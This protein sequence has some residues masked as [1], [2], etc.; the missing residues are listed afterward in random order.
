MVNSESDSLS[1]IDTES[2]AVTHT[3]E[4]IDPTHMAVAPDGRRAYVTSF[5]SDSVTVVDTGSA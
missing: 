4:I 5:D 2:E 1:V 3:V